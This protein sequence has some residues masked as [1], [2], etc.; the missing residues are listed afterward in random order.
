MAAA[1]VGTHGGKRDNSGRKEN[2]SGRKPLTTR[3]DGY[4]YR[5]VY[6][7]NGGKQKVKRV[8]KDVATAISLPIYRWEYRRR[9]EYS[10]SI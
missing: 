4:T 8:T 9:Y 6:F 3:I 5:I 10:R 7:W 1:Q 2:I